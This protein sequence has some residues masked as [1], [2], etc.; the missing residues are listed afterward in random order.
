MS[1]FPHPAVAAPAGSARPHLQAVLA[2]GDRASVQRF[3]RRFSE[4]ILPV[5]VE[6]LGGG[7]TAI[8]VDVLVSGSVLVAAYEASAL[9]MSRASWH[10]AEADDAVTFNLGTGGVF[11]AGEG[12]GAVPVRAGEVAV[13]RT[14]RPSRIAVP[15]RA[16]FI[17]IK[18]PK[19]E[20]V[21][22]GLDPDRCAGP[23]RGVDRA[24]LALL[25]SYLDHLRSAGPALSAALGPLAE[26]HVADLVAAVLRP[27]LAA[28]TERA[29]VKAARRRRIHIILQSRHADPDLGIE[30]VAA[31]LGLSP[32]SVQALLEDQGTSFSDLL[33][34]VRVRAA[35]DILDRP[36]AD[37]RVADV[38]FRVGFKDLSTF[39]RAFR[40]IL[41]ATPRDHRA[42]ALARAT[43]PWPEEA[44]RPLEAPE[45]T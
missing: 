3:S 12:A 2:R 35:A 17:G 19:A 6:P 30:A 9:G 8:R 22:R 23:L 33:R 21:L 44:P 7:P 18:L 38:A 5:D 39:N 27:D 31:D 36:G 32:R 26:R 16:S 1:S 4:T 34:A 42:A 10:A 41:G 37:D 28:E 43:G 29:G 15:G 24:C 25:G 14:G 45:R 11:T 13:L 40:R 20:L